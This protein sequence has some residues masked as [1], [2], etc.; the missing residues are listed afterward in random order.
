MTFY[1]LSSEY[2][3]EILDNKDI[4]ISHDE[5]KYLHEENQ[6][7]KQQ[8][9]YITNHRIVP[10]NN[11]EFFQSVMLS[12][13]IIGFSM[14]YPHGLVIGLGERNHYYRGER[15]LFPSST[16][17]LQ[18]TLKSPEDFEFEKLISYMRIREFEKFILEF[19]Y[20][21]YWKNNCSD[22]HSEAIA[23]HY[24]IKTNLLDIT[25]DFDTALFFATC[26]FENNK[27]RP[28]TKKD[29]EKS[30]NSRYGR[31]FHVPSGALKLINAVSGYENRGIEGV[32]LTGGVWPIGFQPFMRCNM[33]YGY[34][35][36]CDKGY[37]L[38]KDTRFEKLIFKHSEKLSQEVFELMDEGRKI[39]PYEGLNEFQNIIDK[40][41]TTKIFSEDSFEYACEKL[42]YS[43]EKIED[44]KDKLNEQNYVIGKFELDIDVDRIKKINDIHRIII[45]N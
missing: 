6:K 9:E 27:W 44:I 30:K 3:G 7:D 36:N 35:M 19:E 23:Q 45:I 8:C 16:S 12:T 10:K 1:Y 32:Y 5:I 11:D 43:K 4:E 20:V 39:Y 41:G 28:L 26:C 15:E 14:L 37:C 31:I 38:Q 29:I 42:K 22:I 34:V 2:K 17:T 21:Q 18:R 33:Q 13:K 25:N 24:G 40:I